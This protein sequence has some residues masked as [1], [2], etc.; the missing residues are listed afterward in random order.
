MKSTA[1][2]VGLVMI[3]MFLS[4]LLSLVSSILYTAF[5][6]NTLEMNIFSYA[7]QFPNTVFVI[8]GTSLVTVVIP[9]FAGYIGKG[10]KEKAFNFADNLIGLTLVVT[11][12][13]TVLGIIL[14]P[15][16]PLF[17]VFKLNGYGFA[18]AALRIMFPVMIFYGVNYILQ[19]ILQSMGRFN[20]TAFVSVPSSLVVI[21]Y[22]FI[23]GNK[24]GVKGLLFATFIGLSF[25]ALVLIPSVLKTGYRFRLSLN[26]RDEDIK[27]AFRLMLPVLVGTCAYQF[28]ILFNI[29]MAAKYENTITIMALVQN[30]ILYSVLAFIY[31]ITSV[32]F[33]HLTMLAARNDMKNFKRSLSKVLKSIMFFLIPSTVGFVIVGSQLLNFLIAWGKM[34]TSDISFATSVLSLYALG[35]IGIGIKQ[36]VDRAFYS[37]NDTKIPAAMGVVMMLVNITVSLILMQFIGVFGIPIANSISVLLGAGLILC[38]LRRKIGSFGGRG[39]L[40]SAVKVSISSIVMLVVVL[41]LNYLLKS[42][43]FSFELLDKV[44]KLFVPVAAGGAVYCLV[45]CLLKVEEAESVLNKA[46]AIFRIKQVY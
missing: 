46:K 5:Y 3:I 22:V 31:S 10:E 26:F 11:I 24:Y 19:G 32:I 35:I 23:L 28:N 41:L 4:R 33:P 45:A 39:I 37:L 42:Y 13:L 15:V 20:M 44:I 9:V 14:A 17:T 1:K 8:V 25:Q 36:V 16:F 12:M 34:T 27:R 7:I 21:L 40:I 6:G 30:L 2:I 29:T 18:V 43:V 38:L